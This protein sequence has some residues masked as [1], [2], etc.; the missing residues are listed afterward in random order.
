MKI[1]ADIDDDKRCFTDCP[2]GMPYKVSSIYCKQCPFFKSDHGTYIDCINPSNRDKDIKQ[3]QIK[4]EVDMPL[5]TH[6]YRQ[7]RN[8][9][10]N[11]LI[12]ICQSQNCRKS[13]YFKVLPKKDTYC[14]YCG[15]AINIEIEGKYFPAETPID[16]DGDILFRGTYQCLSVIDGEYCISVG[17]PFEDCRSNFK[18]IPCKRGDLKHGDTAYFLG[19]PKRSTFTPAFDEAEFVV[20]IVGDIEI[21]IIDGF[22]KKAN[23]SR[24]KQWFKLIEKNH[25]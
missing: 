7:V 21:C 23:T 13:V 20:K 2:Y 3:N 10:M 11:W 18:W 15:E 4:N 25:L 24:A 16:R 17:A 22:P 5:T 12:I 9:D 6:Q 8:G 14:P 19:F 1:E